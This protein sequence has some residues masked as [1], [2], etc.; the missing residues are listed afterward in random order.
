MLKFTNKQ[1]PTTLLNVQYKK[2]NQN[3]R[4]NGNYSSNQY[5]ANTSNYHNRSN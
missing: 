2:R 4:H 5:N 1:E 3:N